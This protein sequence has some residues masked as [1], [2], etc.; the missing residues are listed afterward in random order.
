MAVDK[1]H[2]RRIPAGKLRGG[3]KGTRFEIDLAHCPPFRGDNVLGLVLGTREKRPHVP[4]MEELEV[5]VTAV[6]NSRSVSGLSSPPAP[7][8]SR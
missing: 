3:L 7:R 1:K 6:A 8:R 4:M 2:I 5:H